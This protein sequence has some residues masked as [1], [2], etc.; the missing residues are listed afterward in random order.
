MRIMSIG[1]H[2]FDVLPGFTPVSGLGPSRAADYF[3][4][5]RRQAR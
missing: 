3:E 4:L 2:Y 5:G 1:A